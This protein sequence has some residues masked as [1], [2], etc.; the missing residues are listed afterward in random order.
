[1]RLMNFFVGQKE[2]SDWKVECKSRLAHV[3]LFGLVIQMM[4]GSK[5]RGPKLTAFEPLFTNWN[6]DKTHV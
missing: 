3:G 4:D 2:I 6:F 1:M 5:T